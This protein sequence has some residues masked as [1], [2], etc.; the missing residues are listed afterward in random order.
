MTTY[1]AFLRA[2]NVGGTG[3]LKMT[4]LVRMCLDL[5]FRNPRTYIQS[6]NVVF[7]SRATERAVT[8]RLKRS[9]ADARK[10]PV[11]VL[12]RTAVELEAALEENP[13]GDRPPNRVLIVFLPEPPPKGSVHAHTAA[14]GE[15]VVPRGREIYVYFPNGQ[16]R[17]KLKLP[18]ADVGTARNMNTVAKVAALARIHAKSPG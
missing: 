5:G 2:I 10:K 17:S 9:L 15:E 8:A 4:D 13:F 7:E 18:L 16:G 6:G 1:V 11:G 14:G 12:V 3:T